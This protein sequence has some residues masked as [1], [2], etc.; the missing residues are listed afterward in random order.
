MCYK[1]QGDQLVNK[2]TEAVYQ[3]LQDKKVFKFLS[4][5]DPEYVKGIIEAALEETWNNGYDEGYGDGQADG[6]E[7]YN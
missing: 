6:P 4:I 2:T 7:Y 3:K 1:E 5:D